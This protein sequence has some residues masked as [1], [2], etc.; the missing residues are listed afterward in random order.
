[1]SIFFSFTVCS[2]PV[3]PFHSGCSPPHPGFERAAAHEHLA[4]SCCEAP[5]WH[6]ARL[7]GSLPCEQNRR[8]CAHKPGGQVPT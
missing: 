5:T 8:R 6:H 3:S 2:S 7:P 1:M 4:A